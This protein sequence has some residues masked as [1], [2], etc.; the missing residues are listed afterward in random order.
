[1]AL[2]FN[3]YKLLRDDVSLELVKILSEDGG[4]PLVCKMI[5]LKCM[6]TI[7]NM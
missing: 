2:T 3:D 6:V 7:Q 1:M 4:Q 5:W